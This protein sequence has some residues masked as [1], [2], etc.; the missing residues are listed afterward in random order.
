MTFRTHIR[1]FAYKL[2]QSVSHPRPRLT[3]AACGA[4]VLFL[5]SADSRC[6]R[7]ARPLSIYFFPCHLWDFCRLIL[8]AN[9]ILAVAQ[10][11][12]VWVSDTLTDIR[13][14]AYKLK[15]S[16]SHPRPRLTRAAC[17]A[18]VLSLYVFFSFYGI[19]AV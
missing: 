11:L 14:F 3:R 16:V 7:R 10:L 13:S 9:K 6:L 4:L 18:L 5:Y 12:S 19:S 2:K 1:S 8:L 15:Q 17:G